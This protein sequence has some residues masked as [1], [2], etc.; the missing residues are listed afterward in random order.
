MPETANTACANAPTG[1]PPKLLVYFDG[2][3]PVCTKEI[4]TYA[5]MD[6][7]RACQWVDVTQADAPLGQ[8]LVAKQALARLHVRDA[9]GRLFSGAKAFALIWQQLP[10]TRWLGVIAAWLPVSL[11]LE[12]GYRAFLRVRPLWRK[13]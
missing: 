6:R 11:V 13:A 12:L 7:E 1:A 2:G 10:A 5:A 8:G 3:C 4:Q 9:D